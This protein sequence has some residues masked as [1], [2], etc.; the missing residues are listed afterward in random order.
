MD[1]GCSFEIPNVQTLLV[2]VNGERVA[3]SDYVV[4]EIGNSYG[5]VVTF[6]NPMQVVKRLIFMRQENSRIL[7]EEHIL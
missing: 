5:D 2:S 3:N 4:S 6:H 1:F 7:Q